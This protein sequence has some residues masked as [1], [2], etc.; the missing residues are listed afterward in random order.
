MSSF[1]LNN[2]TI[3]AVKQSRQSRQIKKHKTMFYSIQCEIINERK[4]NQIKKTA[5]IIETQTK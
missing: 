4:I 3:E 5:R 2:L 1:A